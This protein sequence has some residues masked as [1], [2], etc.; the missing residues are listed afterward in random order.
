M[1][2]PSL[3]P[4]PAPQ[5]SA[6]IAS[7]LHAEPV[8][9]RHAAGELALRF[10]R[11]AM[12]RP[13]QADRAVERDR[14]RGRIGERQA[15][16]AGLDMIGLA[17]A[18]VRFEWR[19]APSPCRAPRSPR[20]RRRSAPT[21]RAR[22]ASRPSRSAASSGRPRAPPRDRPRC[23]I[24]PPASRCPR[25]RARRPSRRSGRSA[26]R[27]RDRGRARARCWSAA[28]ASPASGRARPA[29]GARMASTA[30]SR[31]GAR[32]GGG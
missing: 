11:D 14:H 31:S 30:C 26:P 7:E 3:S 27:A 23:C 5:T 13:G 2:A 10:D 22:R 8:D 15:G 16:L 1:S 29:K 9:D 17:G 12:A 6:L 19:S 25:S 28:R 21:G 20:S 24:R 32:F 18:A 4:A